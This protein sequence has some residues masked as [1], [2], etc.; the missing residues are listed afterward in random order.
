MPDFTTY[1]RVHLSLDEVSEERYDAIVDELASELEARY[2]AMVRRGATHEEAWQ[3]ALAEIPSWPELARELSTTSGAATRAT[4]RPW[5]NLRRRMRPLAAARWVQDIR[6]GCRVLAK[7]RGFAA[8]ATV[9]LAICLGGHA[10]IVTGVN[11]VLLNPLR[12]AEPERIVLMANQYP[13]IESRQLGIVS[14][15]PDYADR[16]AHV[17]ALEEQAMYTFSDVT[18][19]AAAVATRV[20]GIVATPSLFRLLRATPAHGR[21]FTESDGTIG[22]DQRVVLSDGLW[23]ELY[24]SDP[25]VVGRTLRLSG[26][27]FII[28]GILP[29]GFSFGGPNVRF[30]TPLAFTDRQKSDD[31]RH[32]NG[33]FSIGRLRTGSTIEHVRAQ[34]QT[35]DA[36][37]MERLP[38]QLKQ[39]LVNAGFYSSVEP[40]EDVLVRDVKGPLSL[41]WAAALAVLAIGVMNIGSLSVARSRGRVHE[42]G[43]RLA[44]GAGRFELVRQLLVEGLLVALAGALA[45]L[46]LG[47][48]L[49]SVLQTPA[50]IAREM[51][52]LSL[53]GTVIGITLG[54]GALVGVAI[55]LMA[56]LPLVSL[57]PGAMLQHD[58]RTSA[59]G[60]AAR[61]TRRTLVVAQVACAFVLLVSAGLLW[62]SVRNLMNVDTGF[63][64]DGVI[65][66]AISLPAHRYATADDARAFMNRSLEVIRRVPGV[67]AVGATT[68]IPFRGNYESGIILA[69][70]YVP[71]PGES[72]VT[73]IRAVVTPGYFEA[74][75]T[76]LVRGRYFDERDGDP[77]TRS[78]VIDEQL[79]QRFWPS[80]DPI[81]RRMRRP[82]NPSQITTVDENT[83]WLTVIG[84]VRSAKLRGPATDQTFAGTYYLPYTV[85]A[86]REFGYVIRSTTDTSAVIGEVRSA[87]ATVDREAPLFDV[88]TMTERTALSLASRTGTMTLATLFAGV[89]LFLSAVG[90]YGTLA[91]LVTQRKREFGVR[92]AVGST[93]RLLVGL[94]LREGL[95]L[96]FGGVVLGAMI[97]LA[98][99]RV[100]MAQL[101]GVEPTDL[102]V[103]TLMTLGIGAVATL[104][105]LLPARRATQ[106]DVM[107]ALNSE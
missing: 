36:A 97:S 32:S 69:E 28:V 46:V 88:L 101:Y 4:K 57:T 74:V 48:W 72:L 1:V 64:V 104:A 95:T 20:R 77:A 66:G 30:F 61:A 78:I 94:V 15:T 43:T 93:P 81:G 19:E 106:V 27:D 12:V 65:T 37:N 45:G 16:L 11:T 7:D 90:L 59:G 38:P 58:V 60:R 91:Y 25:G 42:L 13:L 29:R 92:V 76:S 17:T 24:G 80:I 62:V 40:L 84:V 82:S 105:C 49:L 35:L 22:N 75:G 96:A 86:P 103:M 33:W 23:R 31:A 5:S 47:G 52:R 100:L 102:R 3:S 14:A 53:N 8:T 26:R 39:L 63:R 44:L 98:I 18:I 73:G 2:S 51:P 9:T 70:G 21:L 67:A 79:A 50:V 71:K 99:R 85:T 56:G 68:I 89:A 41:L 83:R 87:M 34:L 107:Q 6:L 55:G 54:L 10:A